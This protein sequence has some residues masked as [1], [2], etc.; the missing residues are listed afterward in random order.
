VQEQNARQ[1]AQ[2]V[3]NRLGETVWL[4]A[5]DAGGAGEEVAPGTLSFAARKIRDAANLS[6]LFDAVR[7]Y[8]A[9]IGL[10]GNEQA[11]NHIDVAS[12]PKFG[13]EQPLKHLQVWSW[14]ETH[15]LVGSGSGLFPIEWRLVDRKDWEKVVGDE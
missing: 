12:L 15:V 11:E 10:G 9:L 13:G 3:A 7:E 8:A 4:S 2:R 5:S 14:D 6:G 1:I